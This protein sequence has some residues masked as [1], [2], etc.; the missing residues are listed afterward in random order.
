VCR[1]GERTA[2]KPEAEFLLQ[3][4]SGLPADAEKKKDLD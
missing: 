1:G 2:Y 4:I 3:L